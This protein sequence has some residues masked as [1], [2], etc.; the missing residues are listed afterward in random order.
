MSE[1]DLVDTAQKIEDV[2]DQINDILTGNS[3]N[4]PPSQ[5]RQ[6]KKMENSVNGQQRLGDE[7]KRFLDN[8][9]KLRIVQGPE[10][11]FMVVMTLSASQMR[12]QGSV[13]IFF[14]QSTSSG[15]VH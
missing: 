13:C 2:L 6:K 3:G 8:A 7:L 10:Y 5:M 14:H 4:S 12:V 9:G 11:V 15:D 1:K